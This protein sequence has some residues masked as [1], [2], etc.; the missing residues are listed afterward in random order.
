MKIKNLQKKFSGQ[1]LA[2]FLLFSLGKAKKTCKPAQEDDVSQQFYHVARGKSTIKHFE[3][4][5]KL[6]LFERV[7][8]DMQN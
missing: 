2:M 5:L 1:F 4:L 6:K 8:F 7:N 3:F